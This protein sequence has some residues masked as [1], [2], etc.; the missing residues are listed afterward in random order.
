MASERSRIA[1]ERIEAHGARQIARALGILAQIGA[2]APSRSVW[3]RWGT[4]NSFI[5]ISR[6]HTTTLAVVAPCIAEALLATAFVLAAAIPRY[7]LQRFLR[8]IGGLSALAGVLRP[9]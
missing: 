6:S 3:P 8:Q 1:D 2:T 9:K 7:D 4:L 5:G